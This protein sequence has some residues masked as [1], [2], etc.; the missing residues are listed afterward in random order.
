MSNSAERIA[1]NLLQ[2]NA[3]KLN[4]QKPFTWASGIKSPIYCDNRLTLSYPKV[5]TEI[6]EA[7]T[8]VIKGMEF[9]I[10]GGIATAGIPHGA[11]L[12]DRLEKPYLYV[13]SKAKAHGRQNKIEGNL[14]EGA[15]VLLVEDLIS[16][17]MSSLSAVEAVRD[18]GGQV[19]TVLSIFNYGFQRA[20]DAFEAKNCTFVSLSNYDILLKQAVENGFLE[21]DQLELLSRWKVDPENWMN[22]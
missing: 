22:N 12:A 10:I 1:R 19:D 9:D 21:S 4:P 2:I 6:V 7:F 18:A 8:E 15:K 14:P 11:L 13:R 17:G 20:V 16:T 3:I 5:R